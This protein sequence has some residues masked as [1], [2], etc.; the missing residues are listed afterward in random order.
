MIVHPKPLEGK[1]ARQDHQIDFRPDLGL[2][3]RCHANFLSHDGV[4]IPPERAAEFLE[5]PL[6]V[7]LDLIG[8]SFEDLANYREFHARGSLCNGI[9]TRGGRC[10]NFLYQ[11]S[12]NS[13]LD[14]FV[15]GRDDRCSYHQEGGAA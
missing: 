4:A 11:T 8:R 5:D 2:T 15:S 1:T 3:L 13:Y 10:T 9:K 7:L 12:E 6:G 14:R